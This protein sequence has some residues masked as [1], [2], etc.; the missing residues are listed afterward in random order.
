MGTRSRLCASP[1]SE[2]RTSDSVFEA[3]RYSNCFYTC[4]KMLE[5]RTNL[6]LNAVRNFA[7]RHLVDHMV[8]SLA[9]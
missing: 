6:H 3:V 4:L 1:S 9:L 7:S 5:A 8:A 2:A